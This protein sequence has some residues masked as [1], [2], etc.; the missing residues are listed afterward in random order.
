M[1]TLSIFNTHNLYNATVDLFAQL[2]ITLNS[3]TAQVLQA[4]EVLGD[5]YK[6][7]K[8]FTYSRSL[9]FAGQIDDS[10]FGNNP[11]KITCQD[12]MSKT[13]EY[14]GLM[15]FAIELDRRP[16]RTQISDITR[17]FNRK[18]LAM[19]VALL[20]RYEHYVT[21][22]LPER[23]LYKQTWRQGE[24][25][26]K[27][28]MLRDID[29]VNTHRGHKDI[30]EKLSQHNARNFDQLN[31]AWKKTLD[32]K[33]LNDDFYY[34]LAG[35]Y[36]KNGVLTVEGWYQKC[37]KDLHLDLSAASRILN[38]KI[39]DE[40]KPQAVIRI[41]VRMMFIW[42][43]KQKGLIANTFFEKQFIAD[44]LK[45]EDHYYNAVLQNLFFAVLNRKIDE[46]RFRKHHPKKRYDADANDYGVFD[47]LRYQSFFKEGK[48][49]E[50]INQTKQIPFVNGGLFQCHD[51][52]FKGGG[53]G[54]G[55]YAGENS[56][57][58]YIIDGFSDNPKDAATISDH[59]IF[60]L[61]DLFN[62]Y[63]WTIEESTPQEQEI[64]LDPELLGTVFENI[65]GAY[66]PESK[67]NAR[68]SSGSFYT[69]KPIV[70]YMC[71]ESFRETL[72]TRFPNL[73][74]DID[75]LIDNNED[76]LDFPNKNN[77]LAAITS[78]KI[79]DPACGSGAFPMGM[80]NLMVQTVEKLQE[81]KT[82]YKNKLD[83]IQNCIYGVDIQNIAIEIS[84]LR[85]FISLLVD[86]E[87]P[88]NAAD[89]DVLPNLETKFAV[90]N[91]LVGIDLTGAGDLFQANFMEECLKLTRIFTPF[92]T[93]RTPEQKMQIKND[94]E[95][96]KQ[97]LVALLAQND[98][99]GSEIDKIAA[100][101]PFNVCY[102]SPFFDS[103]I[104]FGIK[105]GF[106]VVIGNPPYGF[107]D[108]LT[109]EQKDYFRKIIKIEFSSGD[110]AELFVKISFDR[111]VKE[112]GVLSFIIPKKSL[113]GDAWEDTRVNYWKKY[114]LKFILDSGKSFE[115]VLLEASAF[116][117]KKE[118]EAESSIKIS[119][120]TKFRIDTVGNFS[121]E[122]LFAESNTLQIYKSQ[123]QSIIDKIDKVKSKE[124]LVEGKLG[125]AI[126]TDF[127]SDTETDYQLLK[128]ID[129]EQYNIRSHRWI[130]NKDKLNWNNAKEFLRPK[131]LAQRLVAHIENPIPHLKIT[132][133]Y[134]S[135]GIIIT[136][137]IMSFELDKRL[138][139][140]F[141]LGYLNSKFISW[142]AYN[143]IYARAIRGMD[144]YNFYIQQLPIP[145]I[146]LSEQQPLITLVNQILSAKQ[147]NPAADTTVWERE[148][149]RLVYGLYGLTEEEIKIIEK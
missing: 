26:G 134:D 88:E 18:S 80:F 116:G 131:V 126:G 124:K 39:D 79:L 89:F 84:K 11:Q 45:D 136:N 33:T 92:T 60:E 122:K 44:Y 69:P 27:T 63:V 137:T 73:S 36:N 100:W 86:C 31:E 148:I 140:K 6:E 72:K 24:K 129:I 52:K 38:K 51:Y 121:I 145:I 112:K 55:K 59:V 127:Y 29:T 120:L 103:G 23:F 123:Y 5:R 17:A 96:E 107:R 110:S 81:H 76:Q 149:D 49:D 30:L 47:V 4:K 3:N 99:A 56:D 58:N 12:A 90:A 77:L 97:R 102:C 146:S 74:A 34:A 104:M 66:N 9:Y 118:K 15:V 125:L 82:T 105:D 20:F 35:K 19:P 139:E 62:S 91:T 130:K 113:Y 53:L 128:G 141:W 119:F 61:I 16:T 1:I 115:N 132:A 25:V 133:C 94:F 2:G 78:L 114:N 21:L 48:A 40:L 70:D 65:I 108:V 8:P 57:K 117:L 106:D 95:T 147:S 28:I 75:G 22:A 87:I 7:D 93:S 32:I 14:N 138:D 101:N 142:Y 83:I 42:F 111:F 71:R 10:V 85:F 67:E 43:M 46:R 143:F 98:F 64:A 37:F 13:T 50:F 144:L 41:I 135:E 109:K 68:K 54:M